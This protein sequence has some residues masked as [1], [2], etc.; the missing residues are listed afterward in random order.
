M[1]G[2]KAHE[3]GK[4]PGPWKFMRVDSEFAGILIALGFVVMA[5][6]SMPLAAWFVSGAVLIGVLVALVLSAVRKD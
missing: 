5:F 4:H 2:I 6:V 1:G 3:T